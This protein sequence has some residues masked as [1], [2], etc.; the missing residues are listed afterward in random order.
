[1]DDTLWE[2]APPNIPLLRRL[3]GSDH[4]SDPKVDAVFEGGG[5]KAIAQVGAIRAAEKIG[6]Q[7]NHLG[8]TSG[9]AIVAAGLAAD[10]P[11][12]QIWDILTKTDLTK[13]MDVFYL[14]NVSLL[15]RFKYFYLPLLPNI[16]LF[17]GAFEGKEFEAL[18]RRHLRRKEPDGSW[19]D[20]TFHDLRVEKQDWWESEHRLKIVATDISRR[21]PVVFPDDAEHYRDYPSKDDM[22]VYKAV[23]MSMSIP[24][25]FKPVTLRERHTGKKCL[26][27]DGGASSNYPIWLFDRPSSA[28]RPERPTFGFLL[29]EGTKLHRIC[30]FLGLLWNTVNTA[31]G[32]MDRRLSPWDA[33]RTIRIPVGGVSTTDFNLSREKQ[34]RLRDW[35]YGKAMAFFH[36]FDWDEHMIK[37]R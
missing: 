34:C 7:W 35:G 13:L 19:R 3:V 30:T 31:A 21:R 26:I 23:R 18:M 32:A 2:D 8:G 20:M 37:F 12:R 15:R 33:D 29:D 28:G 4:V 14:P 1:M 24:L 16:L 36:R 9:G 17:K 11:A 22:P 5:V 25:V 10:L 27:V 6:L